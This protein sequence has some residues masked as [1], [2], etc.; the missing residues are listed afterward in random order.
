MD[1]RTVGTSELEVSVVGMGCNNFSRMRTDTETQEGSTD[2]IRAAVEAGITFFDGADIYGSEPGRSEEFLGVALKGLRD[3]VVLSTK[4]GFQDV[5]VA[6]R[7]AWGPK[8]ASRYIRGAVEDSL[9]RLHTDRIDLL[10]MHSPDPETPIEDTLAALTEL[11]GEGKVRYIG[12][13]NFTP[14][15]AVEAAEVATRDGYESFISTQNEYS[16]VSR[17]FEVTMQPVAI[18]YGLGVF[19]YFPLANGLLTGKYTREGGGEGRLRTL[20]P[21]LLADTDW[22]QLEAYQRI[23]DE[24]GHSMLDVTFQWL[25]AQP[26]ISS[27]I[28]GAT[29]PEQ[30]A[31]NA[32]AGS[33]EVPRDVLVAVDDLFAR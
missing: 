4:F 1:T 20:K 19:P 7:E 26:N 21:A 13:S 10:Q 17:E 24:A 33:A 9:R 5:N 16:L 31:Q 14:E 22:D 23:C 25:L 30:M 6:G 12:H 27:V 15:Q 2:V 11:V 18:E 3:Q 29:R 8:G 32:Q 28:A